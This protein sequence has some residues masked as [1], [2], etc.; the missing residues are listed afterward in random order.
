MISTY[1]VVIIEQSLAVN[2]PRL[3]SAQFT[4]VSECACACPFQQVFARD[5]DEFEFTSAE[6]SIAMKFRQLST[7]ESLQRR[8]AFFFGQE[9][10]NYREWRVYGRS[11]VVRV[12]S[13][14]PSRLNCAKSLLPFE[15]PTEGGQITN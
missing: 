1:F 11:A 6:L 2:V 8:V 5:K 13:T 15:N 4:I 3:S 9:F 10:E 14:A 7:R 12:E